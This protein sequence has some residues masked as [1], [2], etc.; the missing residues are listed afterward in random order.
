[1]INGVTELNIM[2]LDILSEFESIKVCV[3]YNVDG[4]FYKDTI[5]FDVSVP[6]DPIYVELKGWNK[7]ITDCKEFDELPQEAKDYIAFIQLETNVPITRVSVGPDR[8]QTIM[9]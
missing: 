2:K 3:G 8:L 1:M 9:R 7:D 4:E 5:P 6:I